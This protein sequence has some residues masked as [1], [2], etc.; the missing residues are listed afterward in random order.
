MIRT[1]VVLDEKLVNAALKAAKMKT[2]SDLI[3]FA[4]R[5]LLRRAKL[6]ELLN[7]H[8]KIKV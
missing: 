6:R 7:L 8:G 1:T 3:D 5:E 4:L 2:R